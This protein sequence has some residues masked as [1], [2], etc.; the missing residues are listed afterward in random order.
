M[1]IYTLVK[2]SVKNCNCCR[3]VEKIATQHKILSAESTPKILTY[4]EEC[5]CINLKPITRLA[6]SFLLSRGTTEGGLQMVSPSKLQKSLTFRFRLAKK[7]CLP[8]HSCFFVCLLLLLLFL[9]SWPRGPQTS[10]ILYSFLS[11]NV[12]IKTRFMESA[13]SQKCRRT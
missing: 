11:V 8:A 10:T 13:R 3:Q 1:K 2:T 6:T 5:L 4:R 12:F 9:S 7:F